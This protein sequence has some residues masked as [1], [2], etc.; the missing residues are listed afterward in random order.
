MEKKNIHEA[1][2]ET[3]AKVINE[4]ESLKAALSN[5]RSLEFIKVPITILTKEESVKGA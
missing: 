3:T 1:M 5:P 4:D 2:D